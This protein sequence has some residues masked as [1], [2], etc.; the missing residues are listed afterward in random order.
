MPGIYEALLQSGDLGWSH[1]SLL[2]HCSGSL[3]E[4][5]LQ[6]AL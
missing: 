2:G 6:A 1:R 3:V 4:F 5:Q